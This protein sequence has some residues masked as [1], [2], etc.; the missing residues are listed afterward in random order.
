[1]TTQTEQLEK[2]AEAY[3]A[4]NNGLTRSELEV[5][6]KKMLEI[7]ANLDK[8]YSE[9]AELLR[10]YHS[11]AFTN[12]QNEHAKAFSDLKGKV[13]NLFIGEKLAGIFAKVEAKMKSVDER[14][15][16][17]K[18]GE[19]GERGLTGK[20][21]PGRDG[22]PDTPK[23]IKDK[24]EKLIGEERLSWKAI[25]GLEEEIKK[26]RNF[27]GGGFSKIAMDQHFIDDETPTGTV[28]GVN[29]DFVLSLKPSPTTSLKVFVNGQK[30]KLTEDYT[31][32]ASTNTITFNTAPPTGSIILCDYR[33]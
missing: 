19:R 6:I 8:K 3:R 20:G 16:R 13:D 7:I 29:T 15:S 22:S 21:K 24:L 23:Q 30:L 1:M 5:V 28:N 31:F 18:D 2:F 14:M 32:T 17:V 25:E 12:V 10:K 33:I 4:F 27:G 26:N 11:S 9:L